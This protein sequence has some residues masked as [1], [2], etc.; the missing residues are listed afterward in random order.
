MESSTSR[1]RAEPDRFL[2]LRE[3]FLVVAVAVPQPVAPV[4]AA[5]NRYRR[6]WR[7][8]L[9]K[10]PLA[11]K[12]QLQLHRWDQMPRLRDHRSGRSC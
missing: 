8:P 3:A 12:L 5:L 7:E 11:G 4:L 6:I 2:L 1:W 9:R 10:V